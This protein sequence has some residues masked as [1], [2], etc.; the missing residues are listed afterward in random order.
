MAQLGIVWMMKRELF[1]KVLKAG[2]VSFLL[3]LLL[4]ADHFR[5]SSADVIGSAL[6]EFTAIL[7]DPETQWMAY[8]CLGIYFTTFLFFRWRTSSSFWR[9][10]NPDLWL[11][12]GLVIMAVIYAIHQV[13]STQAFTFLAGAVLGHGMTF[14]ADF[15]FH[16]SKWKIQNW[17]G[18]LVVSILVIFLA[19]ASV[20]HTGAGY[21]FEYR[22]KPRWSGP[23]D[24]PNIFGLLMGTGVVLALGLT[25]ASFLILS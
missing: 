18:V 10:A 4:F 16:N 21:T 8:L 3:Y 24:N 23:W 17:F 9:G 22:S 13:S 25:V 2:V 20:W 14:W 1:L 5:G 6:S 11:A 7:L 15:D 19:W 12:S